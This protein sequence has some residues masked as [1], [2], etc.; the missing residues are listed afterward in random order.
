[1]TAVTVKEYYDQQMGQLI[2]ES[3]IVRNSSANANMI[4]SFITHQYD[5]IYGVF[6]LI[7][8]DKTKINIDY[9]KNSFWNC[10][11]EAQ[12]KFLDKIDSNYIKKC[13]KKQQLPRYEL[14]IPNNSNE[15]IASY[16]LSRS[17]SIRLIF[18]KG[19]V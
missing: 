18:P 5:F 15:K 16:L 14:Y 1:M 2:V 9:L 12:D 11:S 4:Q 17:I 19:Q 10:C 7:A 3:Q 6:E 13:K 8:N